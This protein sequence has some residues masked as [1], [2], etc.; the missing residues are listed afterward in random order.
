MSHAAS[1]IISTVKESHSLPL[2]LRANDWKLM[3]KHAFVSSNAANIYA[4]PYAQ[5]LRPAILTSA[6][7]HTLGVRCLHYAARHPWLK[8]PFHVR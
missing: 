6:S 7:R 8:E 1:D 5:L 2:W 3:Q 4:N